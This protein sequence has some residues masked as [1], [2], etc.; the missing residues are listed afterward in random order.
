ML[1][2]LV[3]RGEQMKSGIMKRSVA[4]F[5][6][7]TSI[8]LE[9]EFWKGIK[10]IAKERHMTLADLVSEIGTGRTGNLSSTLRVYLLE[11]YKAE[12]SRHHTKS[13]AARQE[14]AGA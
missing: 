4:I 10:E 5:G 12:A 11:H 9:P 14:H 2:Q 3:S 7:K 6:N 13:G 1:V 8:S